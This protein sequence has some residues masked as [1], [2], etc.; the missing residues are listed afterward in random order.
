MMDINTI[1][2]TVEE[3]E[4]S[5]N[6]ELIQELNDKI[7]V[8]LKKQ[9]LKIKRVEQ[10]KVKEQKQR[11]IQEKSDFGFSIVTSL[12]V[13]SEVHFTFKRKENIGVIKK[14]DYSSVSIEFDGITKK[15]QYQRILNP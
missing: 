3:L 8:I 5:G 6:Y 2:S 9:E 15:I 11:E 10:Q 14:I 4:E 12:G 1:L 7:S 13:G